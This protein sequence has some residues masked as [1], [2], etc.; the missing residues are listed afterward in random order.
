[1]K[2]SK[3]AWLILFIGIIIIAFASIYWLYMQQGKA[4]EELNQTLSIAQAALPK[5]ASE[6]ANL[7]SAL[8]EAE[9]RLAEAES[10]LEK[11]KTPFPDSIESMRWMRYYS[12]SLMNGD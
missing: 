6:R 12:A 10:K 4:Q 7:E 2:F 8:V 1:M 9:N 3:T 5:L 11:A